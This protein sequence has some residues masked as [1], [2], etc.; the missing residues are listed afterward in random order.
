MPSYGS[1]SATLL[2]H[3]P[4]HHVVSMVMSGVFVKF[5]KLRFVLNEFGMAWLPFVMW[6]TDMEYR[7]A[8]V[9]TPWL[10][11]L[12]SE[13]M[14]EHIRFSTQPLEAPPD[15]Q[16]LVTLIS[17]VGAED[18]LMFSSDYPHWRLRQPGT[19]PQGV[20]R[21]VAR[22]DL[23]RERPHDLPPRRAPRRHGPHRWRG[24]LTMTRERVRTRV[25][26]PASELPPGARKVVR[27]GRREV[28]VINVNDQL[29]PSSTAARINRRPLEDG[30]LTGTNLP[31][32]VG[33]WTFG[34]P[35]QVLHC[36]WHRYE[37]SLLSG[38]C[39]THRTLRVR[40]YPARIIDGRIVV[41]LAGRV[42]EGGGD[43]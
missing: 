15:P 43:A 24:R 5:P 12:P 3:E 27:A 17:L 26:F 21:G 35:D 23:L 14:R 4:L 36:P 25:A 11:K 1:T 41:D 2:T 39:R 8:R 7:A 20:P 19:G 9:E 33:E 16:K 13:Y 42:R 38:R 18:M 6:R 32:E 28:L 22:Q 37:F 29:T 31:S 40:T 10:E 30:P 34:M